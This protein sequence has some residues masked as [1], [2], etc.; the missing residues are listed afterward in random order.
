MTTATRILSPPRLD[1]VLA[2]PRGR[3]ARALRSRL[4]RGGHGL[5]PRLVGALTRERLAWDPRGIADGELDAAL[6]R[7]APASWP[8]LWDRLSTAPA[9]LVFVDCTASEALPDR[10]AA[11]LAGGIAVATPNKRGGILPYRDWE[12]LRALDESGAA[13]YL[14]STTVGAG[15]PI[16][17]TVR[18]LRLGGRG[19]GSVSAVLSGTLSFVLDRVQEGVRFS[20]AVADAHALGL[21]EPDPRED[22]SG[23]DVARKLLVVLREAGLAL[24]VEDIPVAS[25]VSPPAAQAAREGL[26]PALAREDEAWARRASDARAAGRRL[27][28]LATYDGSGPRVGLS[29]LAAD[30]P[31]ARVRP[32][33]SAAVLRSVDEPER[34]ITLAGP[35]AGPDVTAANLWAE[36]LEACGPACRR[37]EGRASLEV[38]EHVEHEVHPASGG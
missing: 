9:R 17:D 34:V 35:G 30:D 11:L 4:K 20:Q 26:I 1:L 31:L 12:R 7:G 32:G 6:E 24:E 10:Y 5:E 28:F 33:D 3:V 29:S 15:L 22:L 13:R 27:A 2:G 19:L 18:R 8:L 23:A 38:A 21:T 14:R 16:L 36:I 37:A 25:L